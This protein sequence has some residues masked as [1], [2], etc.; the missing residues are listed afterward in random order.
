[1]KLSNEAITAGLGD[2]RII[3]VGGVTSKE[4]AARMR[5]A[6]ADVVGCATLLGKEGIQ[7]FE[8]LSTL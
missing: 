5:Q 2:V 8:M 6:G 3:G 4:A 7:A 1:V